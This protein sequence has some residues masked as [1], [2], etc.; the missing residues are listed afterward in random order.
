[1]RYRPDHQQEYSAS[2]FRWILALSLSARSARHPRT[3]SVM[4]HASVHVVDELARWD[5]DGG[6]MAPKNGPQGEVL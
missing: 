4:C 3:R 6:A 5:D 1:M 2:S